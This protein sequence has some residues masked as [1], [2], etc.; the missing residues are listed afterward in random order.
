[1][2][3]LD[4][5]LRALEES[6]WA[7]AD[8]PLYGPGIVG[9]FQLTALTGLRA[10]EMLLYLEGTADSIPIPPG[11]LIRLGTGRGYIEDPLVWIPILE[12]T[13]TTPNEMPADEIAQLADNIRSDYLPALYNLRE[14]IGSSPDWDKEEED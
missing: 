10:L 13:V 12:H 9:Q 1:M 8:D 6:D 7:Q 11:E 2:I 4:R 3:L 5:S 14:A